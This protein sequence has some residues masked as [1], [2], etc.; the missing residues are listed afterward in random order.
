[1][2][3]PRFSNPEKFNFVPSIN[4]SRSYFEWTCANKDEARHK[5]RADVCKVEPEKVDGNLLN[6]ESEPVVVKQ[7]VKITEEP[8]P[9]KRLD[10]KAFL[11]KID[12]VVESQEETEKKKKVTTKN[13]E[14]ILDTDEVLKKIEKVE[15]TSTTETEK[16]TTETTPAT[17]TVTTTTEE[18]TTPKKQEVKMK[19][20]D[21]K[22]LM[23]K[24]NEASEKL[25]KSQEVTEEVTEATTEA[26][27]TTEE[28]TTT[29]KLILNKK[30][31]IF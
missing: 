10:E 6:N 31:E 24:I 8:V 19:H 20:M 30:S 25:E 11:D 22:A 27:T 12:Q 9:M 17:T 13:S 18:T 14:H 15:A 29:A 28:S 1:M 5:Y 4:Q 26:I 2:F 3:L 23:E 16:P 7:D 21:E